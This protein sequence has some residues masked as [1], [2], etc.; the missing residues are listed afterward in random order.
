MKTG[1]LALLVLGLLAAPLASEAQQAGKVWRIGW[2]SPPSAATGVSE[3]D[4][5]REGLRELNYVEGR[6][7]TIDARWADGDPARLPDLA[8]ALVE[9]NVDIICTAGTPATLAAKQA[10]TTIPIVFGRA[11]FP[12]RTGLVAS[13]ARP[14]GNLTGVTFIGPEYGK[15][16]ELLREIAPKLARVALLYN[17]K[18]PASVLAVNETQQWAKSLRV[19]VEPPGVHDRPTL[20][21][22]FA[23]LRRR[24]PDALM[25]TADPLIASYRTLIVDFATGNR[26]ISMYGDRE[27][28]KVGGLMFY[29]T[30]TTDMWRQAANY[31]DRILRGAKPRNLPVEQPTKFELI[32]NMKTAKALGLTIPQSLLLRADQVIE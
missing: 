22:A 18:N 8:R 30:S 24:R 26:F 12:E 5:L 17:D 2:L 15:R 14:G 31:I 4:A 21:T 1:S 20:E 11:A 29:G 13:L 9:L 25:T 6:N 10:T 19:V 27:Y 7:I 23:G 16:L 32:I 3:L 28:V